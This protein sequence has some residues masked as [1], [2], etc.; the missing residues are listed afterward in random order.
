MRIARWYCPEGRQTFSLLPDFLAARRPGL[1]ASIEHS[2]AVA[3][4]AKSME[5]AADALRGPEVTLPSAVRWLRRRTQ[6][7][8]TALAHVMPRTAIG[9]LAEQPAS[10][11]DLDQGC[12]LL[13][14][15][16]S[17]SPEIL[18]RIPPPLGFRECR[19]AARCAQPT[20]DGT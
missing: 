9:S 13:R 15:R 5:A 7:V 11:I 16:Q 17:L 14:L 3:L 18:N 2:V 10:E 8:K 12:V 20:R 1:L 4:S 6:A 19:A